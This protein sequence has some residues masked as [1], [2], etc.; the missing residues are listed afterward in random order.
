[1]QDR[2]SNLQKSETIEFG[3][4]TA[5]PVSPVHTLENRWLRCRLLTPITPSPEQRE[6]MVRA[7]QLP[8]ETQ[9]RRHILDSPWRDILAG[10]RQN[11]SANNPGELY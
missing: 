7:T 9:I 4:I 5:V 3:A 2:T 11:H 1:M 10:W 8:R 6:G